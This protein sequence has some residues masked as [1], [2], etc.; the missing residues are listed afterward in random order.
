MFRLDYFPRHVLVLR[1]KSDEV[2]D[3]DEW[4][5]RVNAVTKTLG[6]KIEEN[7]AKMEDKIGGS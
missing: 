4:R 6:R 1:A 3:T 5:G 2:E 7:D